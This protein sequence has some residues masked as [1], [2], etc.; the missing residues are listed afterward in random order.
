MR[1]R[2]LLA[3]LALLAGP[4]MAQEK[5]ADNM[6]LVRDKLKADKKLVVAENMGLT[7]TEAK[8]FWPVY[9]AFQAD[10]AKLNER[11]GAMIKNYAANYKAMTDAV[12][13]SMLDEFIAIERDR[14]ALLQSYRSKFGAAVPPLK[15]ARYYQIENKIRAVINYELASAI[16]LM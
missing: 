10:Q 9:D 16:P 5:P 6:Q 11:A 12:A 13:N 1:S 14:T 3:A 4:A 7:E 8:A 2:Y 15:V